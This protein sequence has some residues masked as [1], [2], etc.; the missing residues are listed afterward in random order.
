MSSRS[1]SMPSNMTHSFARVPQATIPRSQFRSPYTWKSDFYAGYLVPFL[2]DEVLPGDTFNDKFSIFARVE[3]A[4]IKPIMDNLYLDTFYFYVPNRLLW[5][6]WERFNGAQDNPDDTTDYLIPI[7]QGPNDGYDYHSLQDYM[8]LPVGPDAP[9]VQHCAFWTRAYNLIWNE[10]F[11]NQNLQE[12]VVV[13]RDDGPDDP[14]DYVLLRRN[15][16]HDYFTSA[17]P[18]PQ[19]GPAASLSFTGT[20]PVMGIGV[21]PGATTVAGPTDVK[22][23]SGTSSWTNYY[24]DNS[25]RQLIKASG[26]NGNPAPYADLTDAS[27][28]TINEF[29]QA[30]Q[31][32]MLLEMD[33]RGG[34][35]YTEILRAHFSVISPDFRLQR[36]E[37]LGGRSTRIS[38]NQVP[39]TNSSDST[40]P[41]G[42]L[43]AYATATSQ[44]EGYI[45]SFVEHGIIIAMMNVRADLTYQS[46]L[47]R[48]WSRR[49]RFDF[50]W[51]ALAH[52]GEQAIIN[53]EI[54]YSDDPVYNELVFGYQERSAEYRY[55]PSAITGTLRSSHP[56]SLDL[57]HLAQDLE[58]PVLSAEF[59]EE[60]P[61]VDR[62]VTVTNEPPFIVDVYGELIRA[63]PMPTFSTPGLITRL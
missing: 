4:L 63:R 10:F 1:P 2:V 36:P 21:L 47:R 58:E 17:L 28:F 33:A 32:Q 24:D 9:S 39:Q 55:V 51:P 35:R 26:L 61:P 34:T 5:N 19:K 57:W 14:A 46:G 13:D 44:G 37:Y 16:R 45:K 62:V 53:K 27:A 40:S 42:N 12:S 15:K 56:Q 52:L 6:N 48:M 38:I 60:N 30:Y 59:Q 11:R 23:A 18:W 25:Q 8:A 50:Y 3:P 7:C 29:R 22:D 49:T 20:A 43:A 31:L 54:Y 41:Q